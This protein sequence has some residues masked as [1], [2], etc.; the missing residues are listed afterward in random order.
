MSAHALQ[1]S[2]VHHY[3]AGTATI[4]SGLAIFFAVVGVGYA[5]L[6]R[7]TFYRNTLLAG[8][9]IGGMTQDEAKAKLHADVLRYEK[10]FR[11]Q[12]GSETHHPGFVELGISIDEEASLERAWEIGRDGPMVSR[13]RDTT[14]SVLSSNAIPLVVN[15]DEDRMYATF[16]GLQEK[17]NVPVLNARVR[18]E[19][20][21][22]TI[23]P[24][25]EGRRLDV[26]ELEEV[27]LASVAALKPE[28]IPLPFIVTQPTIRD[29]DASEALAKVKVAV[30]HPLTVTHTSDKLSVLPEMIASW[31]DFSEVEHT[32][33]PE[34]KV[35]SV[36]LNE[37]AIWS[38]LD[39]LAATIEQPGIPRKVIPAAYREEYEAGS[40]AHVIA[41]E[42]NSEAIRE[43]VFETENRTFEL[44]TEDAIPEDEILAIPEPPHAEGKAISVDIKK[45]IAYAWLD[46][47]LQYFAKVS[48]G[49]GA[50]KTPTGN[51]KVYGKTRD[52]KMSGAD[53]YLP[54]I[55]YILWYN[56]DYSLHGTYWHNNFGTPMSHGC[57]NLSV[58]DAKWFFEFAD[59]GTPVIIFES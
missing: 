16:I 12:D 5:S 33:Y 24:S 8:L 22:V 51:F 26:L 18:I 35:L 29:E 58:Q 11:L 19:L 42:K 1:K 45:Q 59:V 21:S 49:K 15:V 36:D 46:G 44:I 41:R 4:L 37:S 31:L 52:Q 20:P 9:D 48:S 10:E 6:N 47:K 3:V 55:P 34:R 30:S 40:I 23:V 14:N 39:T 57:S 56:G 7:D 53:F 54:H 13:L 2:G 27:L 32:L 28:T 43:A 17:V 38:Y 50:F 25:R